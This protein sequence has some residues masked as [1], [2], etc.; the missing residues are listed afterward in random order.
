MDP[1]DL[2]TLSSPRRPGTFSSFW[3]TRV[4]IFL[5]GKALFSRLS[6]SRPLPQVPGP[7][8]GG[9]SKD[10]AGQLCQDRVSVGTSTQEAPGGTEDA[11]GQHCADSALCPS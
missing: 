4:G 5:A 2:C 7:R 6:S 3:G 9:D 10:Q 11:G 8:L 1:A